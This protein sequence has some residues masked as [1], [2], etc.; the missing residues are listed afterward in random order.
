MSVEEHKDPENPEVKEGSETKPQIDVE[1]LVKRM[2]M[3]ERTNE[4]LLEESKGYKDKYRGLRD[5]VEAEKKQKLEQEEN[6]KEL[7]DIEK[8][9]VSDMSG[10]LVE[11]KKKVAREKVI[12]K[13]RDLGANKEYI[14]DVYN[15]LPK[16]MLSFDEE[17]LTF[18][19]LDDAIEIVKGK[20]PLFFEGAKVS[21][22]QPSGRPSAVN[23]KVGYDE[24][25]TKEKDE[26]F[27]KALGEF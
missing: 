3:L 14:S 19:G 7:L 20:K 21:T 9:K 11:L 26:L 13:I 8:N 1:E 10:S 24:L 6:W 4:R 25:S 23:G 2:E 18:D 5:G 27:V 15:N 22:G 17:N 16:D 12:N